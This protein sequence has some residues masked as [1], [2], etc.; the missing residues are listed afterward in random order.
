MPR[1]LDPC[2]LLGLER[3]AWF[4]DL[5]LPPAEPCLVQ[6]LCVR[7]FLAADMHLI[8]SFSYFVRAVPCQAWGKSRLTL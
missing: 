5:A 4:L 3:H 6:A 8:T 1:A 7:V 2:S